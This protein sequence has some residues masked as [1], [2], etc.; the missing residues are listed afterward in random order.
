M[1]AG[2][3]GG[4]GAVVGVGLSEDAADMYS[5]GVLAE[6]EALGDLRVRQ[7]RRDKA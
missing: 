2:K 3:G 6:E 4:G 5:D 1:Q 7:A